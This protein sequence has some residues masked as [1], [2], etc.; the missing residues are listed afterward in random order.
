MAKNNRK[1]R[2]AKGN[3]ALFFP[4]WCSYT[5]R[6]AKRPQTPNKRLIGGKLK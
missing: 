3:L 5:K 2:K 1:T 4:K 6:T